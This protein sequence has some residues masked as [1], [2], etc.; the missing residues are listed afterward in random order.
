ML[1]YSARKINAKPALPYS[2]L[3]PDTNSDSPSA[4]SKGARLVS[5]T[6]VT[7]QRKATG[8]IRNP[9]HKGLWASVISVNLNLPT[10]KRGNKR[11]R[12]ILI[13][14]EI[15]WA[16][17]RR[18]PSKAYLELEAHPA[19]R[20]PYTLREETQRK[21][22]TPHLKKAGLLALGYNCQSRRAN[23]KLKIGA[24]KYGE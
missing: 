10:K 3:N 21:N 8:A 22:R 14:Y 1:A 17:A 24:I 2:I 18:L 11:M 9:S 7:N 15:V 20:V 16:I 12:A 19:R 23:T 13:S 6:Q 4:K 5:A